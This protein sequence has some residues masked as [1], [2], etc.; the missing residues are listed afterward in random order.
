MKKLIRIAAPVMA[1]ALMSG[2]PMFAHAQSTPTQTAQNADWNT[3]PAG[4]EQAKQGYRDG[5]IR[6]Y[7][8]KRSDGGGRGQP[9]SN[10]APGAGEFQVQA[11][12]RLTI[13]LA[14]LGNQRP[15]VFQ[16]ALCDGLVAM[17]AGVRHSCVFAHHPMKIRR[18]DDSRTA[19]IC[20]SNL[21]TK[22][23]RREAAAA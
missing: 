18:Q 11:I 16:P 4:S 12:F 6:R 1:M 9:G 23:S 22:L 19:C 5:R 17:T 20:G 13:H 15:H 3:P 7:K 10:A 8:L 2:S 21:F 14:V